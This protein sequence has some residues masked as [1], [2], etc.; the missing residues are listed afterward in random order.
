MYLKYNMFNNHFYYG[1]NQYE[2]FLA[3]SKNILILID[4]PYGGLVKL[5]SHTLER[6]QKGSVQEF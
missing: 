1:Q 4:P 2:K 3:R 6:I 5:V